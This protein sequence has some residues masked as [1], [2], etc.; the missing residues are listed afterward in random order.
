[1]A[2]VCGQAGITSHGLAMYLLEGAD[3]KQG[4]AC[5]GGECFGK[6]GRGFI[7]F[8]CAVAE[9]RL[10]QAVQFIDQAFR[11]QDRIAAYLRGKPQYR[12]SAAG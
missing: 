8:S 11:R 6:A 9:D 12:L 7:R 10:R 3:P 4:V 5:L 2:E 1:V